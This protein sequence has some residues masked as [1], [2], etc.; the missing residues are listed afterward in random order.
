MQARTRVSTP[1]AHS[2]LRVA[3]PIYKSSFTGMGYTCFWK[4]IQANHY[5]V[6]QQRPRTILVALKHEYADHFIWPIGVIA[7]PPTVGQILYNEM[8]SN[9]WAGAKQ[10]AEGAND[11][12]PTIVGGSKKHGGAD[13]GPTRAKQAWEKLGVNGMGLNEAPP[14]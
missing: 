4:L 9:G 12:G 8:A 11:I 3:S 10:W 2:F 13:L 1:L 7:P 14:A 5:G 6:P